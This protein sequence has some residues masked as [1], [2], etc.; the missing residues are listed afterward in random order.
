MINWLFIGI[1]YFSVSKDTME[2]VRRFDYFSGTGLSI[3]IAIKDS[4]R[5]TMFDMVIDRF[6]L[7]LAKI[8]NQFHRLPKTG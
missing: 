1:C 7:K 8:R 4:R 3:D 6:I 2:H 5:A